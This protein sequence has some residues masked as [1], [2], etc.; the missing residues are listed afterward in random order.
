M[1]SFRSGVGVLIA[2]A[3]AG[4]VSAAD[5]WVVAGERARC[6]IDQVP[7][8]LQHGPVIVI[9]VEACPVTDPAEALSIYTANSA[10]PD[11]A[12]SE[13]G[14]NDR[15]VVY[16]PDELKCLARLP[17]DFMAEKVLLPKTPRC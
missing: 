1:S 15:F 17:F 2:L 16:S 8:Y 3:W 5:A 9:Y 10:L 6:L 11:I 14:G 4:Q 13:E 7:A 12:V